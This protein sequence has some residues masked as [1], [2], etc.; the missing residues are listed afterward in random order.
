[1][2]EHIS[3]YRQQLYDL[4]VGKNVWH[5]W[6]TGDTFIVSVT[7]NCTHKENTKF[8]RAILN[9][10]SLYEVMNAAVLFLKSNAQAGSNLQQNTTDSAQGTYWELHTWYPYEN[11]D[12]CN[13]TE[14]TVTVKVFTVRNLSDIM[15]SDIFKGYSDKNFHTRPFPHLRHVALDRH[16]ASGQYLPPPKS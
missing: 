6:N 7:S 2:A 5:S 1:M 9:Q 15:R 4:F 12:R 14:G 10:L 8:S 11:S 3:R 13:P 16:T